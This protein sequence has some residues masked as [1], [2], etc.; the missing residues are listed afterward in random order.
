M[1]TLDLSIPLKDHHLEYLLPP[2]PDVIASEDG[3]DPTAGLPYPPRLKVLILDNSRITDRS[4][5]AVGRCHDLRLLHLANTKIS[6][7]FLRTVLET[8]PLVNSL[9]L[10]SARGIPALMRRRF[11]EALEAGEVES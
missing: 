4:A 7:A 10:T 9:N 6:P 1:Q 2:G 3:V 11:F 5:L 8:C